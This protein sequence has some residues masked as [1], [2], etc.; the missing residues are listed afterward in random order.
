MK[1]SSIRDKKGAY[2]K[3]AAAFNLET[4]NAIKPLLEKY[5]DRLS[6]DEM[7]FIITNQTV[8]DCTILLALEL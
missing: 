4:F 2:T 6:F 7:C 3:D 5:K 8:S 1:Q